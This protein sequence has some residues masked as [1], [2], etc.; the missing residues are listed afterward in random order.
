MHEVG[1]LDTFL[2]ESEECQQALA[3]GAG[4]RFQQI[5]VE[6][7]EKY[8]WIAESGQARGAAYTSWEAM[9][10][11]SDVEQNATNE[12]CSGASLVV[13]LAP[14]S[15]KVVLRMIRGSSY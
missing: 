14:V 5:M 2:F 4:N 7:C 11:M 8:V 1:K 15:Q 13:V 12:Q 3:C 6:H 10:E 9:L